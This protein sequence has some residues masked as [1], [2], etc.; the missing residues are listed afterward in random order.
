MRILKR[1]IFLILILTGPFFTACQIS[2]PRSKIVEK[3][4][5]KNPNQKIYLYPYDSVWRAAQLSLKYPIAVNNMDNGTLET[6]YIKAID[7]FTSPIETQL[8]SAGIK[9]KLTFTIVKGKLDNK[10]S[11]RVTINKTIEKQRDFF[12]DIEFLESDGL[13]EKTLFYRMEREII[14]E[15]AIKRAAQKG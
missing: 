1:N 11:V 8:P 5:A 6:E 15:E 9:Y 14:I 7:G 3:I 10:D 4:V 2:K 12:S 13:E